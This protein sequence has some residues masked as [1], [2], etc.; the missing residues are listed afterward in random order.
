VGEVY[1]PVNHC[2]VGH[3]PPSIKAT[4]VSGSGGN[5]PGTSSTAATLADFVRDR[6]EDD[7]PSSSGRATPGRATPTLIQPYPSPPHSHPLYPLSHIRKLYS[8]PQAWGQCNTFLSTYLKGIERIDVSS[9]SR[10][11]QLVAEDK[12]GRSAAISS[13]IA[14]EV[15]GVEFLAR[16]VQDEVGNCTRFLVLR[17]GGEAGFGTLGSP[18][19]AQEK[20]E[21]AEGEGEAQFGGDDLDRFKTL[22]SF[23][24]DHEDPGALA[25]AL[26]V[27]KAYKLNLT[28]INARPSGIVPWNYIFIVEIKGRKLG[29]EE[30]KV[31]AAL[32]DLG[33]T[34][35]GWRWLG[36]WENKLGR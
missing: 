13:E 34:T 26:A 5:G 27:F 22:I 2:L 9:T 1:V 33:A 11:A 30:G 12:S 14:A 28:S 15:N 4:A 29:G 35:R 6:D 7:S 20:E 36:S 32:R 8:H 3:I 23:T 10:A 18:A 16:R 24:V 31:N 25:A 17:K 21:K 19:S